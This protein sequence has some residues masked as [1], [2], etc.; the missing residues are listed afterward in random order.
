MDSDSM[1]DL[2]YWS[3]HLVVL[4]VSFYREGQAS[5]TLLEFTTVSSA[6]F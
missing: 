3:E 4:G 1:N 2:Q 5:D 6:S